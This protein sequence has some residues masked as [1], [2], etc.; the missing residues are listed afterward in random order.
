VKSAGLSILVVDDE[1]PIAAS[2][3]SLL[4]RRGH[5]VA[6]A[7]S[8]EEALE[9]PTPDVLVS[10]VALR[11]L[12][13]LDLLSAFKER[14]TAPRTIFLSSRPTVDMCRDALLAGG[15][16]FLTKPFR[17]DDLLRAIEAA[18]APALPTESREPREPNASSERESAWVFERTYVSSPLCVERAARDVTGFAMRCGIGPAARARVASATSELV[19]NARRHGYVN[20]PGPILV[21]AESDGREISV[22]VR[23]DGRGFEPASVANGSLEDGLGRAM[24]LSEDFEMHSA[25][26]EGTCVTLHFTVFRVDFDDD[27][28]IDLTE[29]DFLTPDLSRRVLHALRKPDTKDLFQLSPALAVVIGRLLAGPDQRRSVETALWS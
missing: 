3:A 14:G 20:G 16:E 19:D 26:D 22:Q 18:P 1:R 10:D 17:F 27:A 15:S 12:S 24:A 13:G 29:L 5:R 8:A 28:S 23:D 9:F 7:A 6:I 11:G 25:P 2:I 4:T 21:R